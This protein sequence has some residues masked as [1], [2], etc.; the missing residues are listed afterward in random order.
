MNE[1]TRSNLLLFW[2]MGDN[3]HLLVVLGGHGRTWGTNRE[4]QVKNCLADVVW[5]L[6]SWGFL[7]GFPFP[8]EL[9]N[10]CAL[11]RAQGVIPVFCASA[12]L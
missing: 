4:K 7:V 11:T 8:L 12:K 1:L 3:L 5:G 6:E 10:R 9:D 2:D